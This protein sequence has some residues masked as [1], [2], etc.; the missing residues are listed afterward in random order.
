IVGL[1]IGIVVVSGSILS[2]HIAIPLYHM[3]FLDSD[4]ALATSIAGAGAEDIAGAIWS[5][6]IRYLG[7]GAML[8]GGVW[9]LFALRQSLL[10]GVRT[11]RAGARGGSGAQVAEPERDLPMKWVLV[12]LVAFVGPLLLLSQAIVGMWPVSIPMA[13]IMIAAGFLFVSVSAYL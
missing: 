9:T 6:K 5:A 10:S 12:A 4:P 11:G 2:W 3:F 8:I 1:N 7:V 13:I